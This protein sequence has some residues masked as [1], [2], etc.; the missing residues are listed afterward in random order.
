ME[1][2]RTR[3]VNRV[4]RH[5]EYKIVEEKLDGSKAFKQQSPLGDKHSR[6]IGLLQL[7][8]VRHPYRF[9]ITNCVEARKEEVK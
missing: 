9:L 5:A 3:Y 4:S 7:R 8:C 1:N 6:S 2:V